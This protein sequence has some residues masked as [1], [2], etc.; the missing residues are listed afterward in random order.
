MHQPTVARMQEH[1]TKRGVE[2]NSAR[3]RMATLPAPAEVLFTEGIWV[4][5]VNLQGVYI[6][7]GIPR[8][9]QAMISAHQV[10][11][12][13]SGACRIIY[14]MYARQ[15]QACTCLPAQQLA[16]REPTRCMHGT[17]P[18][19]QARQMHI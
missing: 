8:L 17:V 14:Q 3:L 2:L 1:Y 13:G 15:L 18:A 19:G 11:R 10:R 6:L 4:P 16:L 9:F 12:Q 7:P 5:L